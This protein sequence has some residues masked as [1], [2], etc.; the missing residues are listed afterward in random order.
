MGLLLNVAMKNAQD[1]PSANLMH[2]VNRSQ[3]RLECRRC[4]EICPKQVY[5]AN[6]SVAPDWDVCQN[7]GLCVTACPTR[8]LMP[9][10]LNLKR[11]LLLAQRQGNLSVSCEQAGE[12]AD[13][14]EC[15]IAQMPWEMLACLAL[16]GRLT[17]DTHACA[18]CPHE[19]CLQLLNEQLEALRHFLGPQLW[20]ER[21]V[22]AAKNESAAE[23]EHV[24]RRSFFQNMAHGGKKAGMLAA[25]D[26][27]GATTDGLVYRRLLAQRVREF[28]GEEKKA[29]TMKLPWFTDACYGCGICEKLCPNR[30]IEIGGEEDGR[31]TI[32]LIPYKCTGCGVCAEVCREG[33]IEGV[34]SVRVKSLDR[35]RMISAPSA[36]CARCGRAIR[37]E[38][39]DGYCAVCRQK[40]GSKRSGVK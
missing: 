12:K 20:Q 33:G 3:R 21:I 10:P 8:C 36:S 6:L 27:L 14:V 28:A 34:C 26:V 4:V 11:H 24:G 17:L 22:F 5:D 30:A 23:R 39:T 37:P 25:Q 38:T 9:S 13:H 29:W 15:C 32:T 7:C 16:R 1:H 40:M 31:R 2:C 18:Q 35:V 19:D